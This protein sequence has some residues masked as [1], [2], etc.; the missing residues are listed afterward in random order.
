MSRITIPEFGINV[1][2]DKLL[3]TR[4][5]IGAQDRWEVQAA[6]TDLDGPLSV[7]SIYVGKSEEDARSAHAKMLNEMAVA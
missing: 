3:W 7:H 6:F 1:N 5:Y 4:V 2:T